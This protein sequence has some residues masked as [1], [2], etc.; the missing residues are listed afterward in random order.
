[1]PMM[2]GASSISRFAD[3]SL[4]HLSFV[5]IYLFCNSKSLFINSKKK[6]CSY[7]VDMLPKEGKECRPC[8]PA[9]SSPSCM[10][11]GSA[12]LTSQRPSSPWKTDVG[13]SWDPKAWLYPHRP[14]EDC[15]GPHLRSFIPRS[16]SSARPCQP[17]ERQACSYSQ[18]LEAWGWARPCLQSLARTWH[19]L[20]WG[21]IRTLDLRS[22]TGRGLHF[23]APWMQGGE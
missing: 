12:F 17:T 13:W 6:S 14:G 11:P 1:M 16:C 7:S 9:F 21:H 19:T 8:F 20:L 4:P 2:S 10:R 5:N 22:M 15:R 23:P 18:I 3:L